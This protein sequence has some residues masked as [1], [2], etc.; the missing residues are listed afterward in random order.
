MKYF[1]EEAQWN[2]KKQTIYPEWC[3]QQNIIFVRVSVVEEPN[4]STGRR[5]Q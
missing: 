4:K 2:I 3:A 5:S 1:N